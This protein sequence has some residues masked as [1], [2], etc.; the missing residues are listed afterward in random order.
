MSHPGCASIF[1][2]DSGS[3]IIFFN[4][5]LFKIILLVQE[6]SIDLFRHV[7]I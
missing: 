2:I 3:S 1:N 6:E 4:E 7:V 5:G